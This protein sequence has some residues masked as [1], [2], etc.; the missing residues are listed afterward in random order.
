MAEYPIGRNPTIQELAILYG[1]K[2]ISEMGVT[3]IEGQDINHKLFEQEA[4]KWARKV[5]NLFKDN[6]IAQM[7]HETNTLRSRVMPKLLMNKDD[8]IENVSFSFYRSGIFVAYGVGKYLI[9]TPMGVIRGKKQN[10]K[11]HAPNKNTFIPYNGKSLSFKR[12]PNDWF[13]TTLENNIGSLADL[14]SIYFG[15]RY[16]LA[17]AAGTRIINK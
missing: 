4:E 9:H 17:A 5:A 3:E 7:P 16:V 12:K 6:I 14:A 13:D 15:D 11:S 2:N 8:L 10:R 1:Y